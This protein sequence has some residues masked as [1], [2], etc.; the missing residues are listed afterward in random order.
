MQLIVETDEAWSI[1][2]LIT[3]QIVDGAGLSEEGI[4]AIRGWRKDRADGT[5]TMHTLADE[6]NAALG[7][8]I[9]ERTRRTIRRKGRY[10]S[11]DDLR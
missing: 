7:N 5:E 3:A 8:V 9:D 1:M 4:A 6:I 10:V 11:S 2:S